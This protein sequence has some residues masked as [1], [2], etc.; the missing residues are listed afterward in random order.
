MKADIFDLSGKAVSKVDLPMQFEEEY[1]PDLIKKIFLVIQ[2]NK[3]QAYGASET[4]GKQYSAKIS[5]RRR[6]Y[7]GSYGHGI[8]RVPRK[9]MWR[10]GMQFGWVGAIAPGTVGGRKAHPPKASKIWKKDLNKKERRKA[11]RSAIAATALKESFEREVD[12]NLP[13]VVVKGI[14]DLDKTKKIKEALVKLGL[15][16]EL[17]RSK[18]KII[19]PGKGTRRGRKYKKKKGI[20]FVVSKDCKLMRSA[21]NLNCDVVEVNNLN[22]ETLMPGLKLRL[23]VWSEDAVKRLKDE[24][25]FTNEK[26][27]KKVEEVKEKPV[28]KEKKKVKGKIVKEKKKK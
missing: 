2:G 19:R 13:L 25:L 28:K 3:R 26:I 11:I 9:V 8:S 22:V 7:R 12:K 6:N 14:E 15:E 21:V 24:K 10:R 18:E 16:S 4:A 27:K 1:R 5:K 17:S 23:V 20:L